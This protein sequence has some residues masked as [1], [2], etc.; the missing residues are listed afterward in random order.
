MIMVYITPLAISPDQLSV[1]ICSSMKL[2]KIEPV[3]KKAMIVADMFIAK[4]FQYLKTDSLKPREK[5]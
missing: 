5:R 2:L 4:S 3:A 1:G